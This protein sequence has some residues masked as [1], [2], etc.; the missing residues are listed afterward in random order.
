MKTP[1]LNRTTKG[2]SIA[3][4]VGKQGQLTLLPSTIAAQW[5]DLLPIA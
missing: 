3:V 5:I 4:G 1:S 2:P